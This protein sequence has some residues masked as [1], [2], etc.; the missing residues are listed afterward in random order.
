MTSLLD[1]VN[2]T[3]LEDEFK[4]DY[5]EEFQGEFEGE[6]ESDPA[7]GDE[8]PAQEPRGMA[9]RAAEKMKPS[10]SPV[11]AAMRRRIS[12]EIQLYLELLGGVVS[13]RCEE[14]GTAMQDQTK[15]VADRCASI[16]GR[17]PDLANKLVSTGVLADWVGLAMALKPVASTVLHHRQHTEQE[18]ESDSAAGAYVPPPYRPH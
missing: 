5:G 4:P 1:R 10:A 8:Q 2:H 13:L 14:C 9:R 6:F 17:Y 7:P 12:A 3:E 16:L 18:P 11:T 15:A